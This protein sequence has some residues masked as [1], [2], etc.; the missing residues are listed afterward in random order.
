MRNL[1]HDEAAVVGQGFPDAVIAR[2]SSVLSFCLASLKQTDV[3]LFRHSMNVKAI[4]ARLMS[5]VGV[6]GSTAQIVD[7]GCLL[8]D[9]G[10]TFVPDDVLRKPGR[11]SEPEA[12]IMRNHTLIGYKLLTKLDVFFPHEVLDIVLFHH[13]RPGGKGYPNQME[14]LPFH[15]EVAAVCDVAS[16]MQEHRHYRKGHSLEAALEEVLK[17]KWHSDLIR[18]LNQKPSVFVIAECDRWLCV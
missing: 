10:K 14:E 11:Y 8:H 5:A 2:R 16:A 12:L 1:P 13:E 7:W 17:H 9:V 15:V 3:T 6:N 4:A 18:V